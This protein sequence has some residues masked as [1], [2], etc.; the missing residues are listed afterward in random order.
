MARKGP[1]F[2][3]TTIESDAHTWNL[4]YMESLL[5]EHGIRTVN[6]GP[7]VSAEM[8]VDAIAAH[9]PDAV[10]VSSVNGH[11]LQQARDLFRSAER[12]LG[13]SLPPML[14]GGKLSTSDVK[15]P[16]IRQELLA[17]GYRGVFV[18]DRAIQEFR[19]WLAEFLGLRCGAAL[20][21]RTD[22]SLAAGA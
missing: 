8:T 13:E 19:Q 15:G 2:L 1:T 3:L 16:A 17:T 10:I 18:G 4:I 12:R 7:C 22:A 14:I 20:S 6:L 9:R 5:E 11:G 21:L